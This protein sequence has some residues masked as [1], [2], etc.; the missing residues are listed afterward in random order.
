M[1]KITVSPTYQYPVEIKLLD[2]KGKEK[3][4]GFKAEFKRLAQDDIED[5]L[6][7]ID[8]KDINDRELVSMVLIGWQGIQ[9]EAGKEL[10]FT[11]ENMDAVLNIHPVQARV[12]EAW[13]ASLAGAQR[14]N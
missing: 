9:D 7:R 2:E 3:T 1:F 14:K 6:R 12:A 11:P 8:E 13:F 10:D 4:M 5:V